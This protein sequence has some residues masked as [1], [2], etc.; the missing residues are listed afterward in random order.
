M[1]SRTFSTDFVVSSAKSTA[2]LLSSARGPSRSR[3]ARH[4][5]ETCDAR[6]A[7]VEDPVSH[8]GAELRRVRIRGQGEAPREDS[9]R[10]LAATDLRPRALRGWPPLAL[11]R[12]DPAL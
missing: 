2:P 9:E 3:H 1:S 8:V 4:S 5:L 12:D 10:P 6:H 7:D 11:D